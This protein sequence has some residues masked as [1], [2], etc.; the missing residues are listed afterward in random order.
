MI[1]KL[2][3]QLS[4]ASRYSFD[5]CMFLLRSEFAA[6]VEVYAFFWMVVT[7]LL[8]KVS[9]MTLTVATILFLI[10]IATEALNTAIEVIIDRVSPEISPAG[11]KAKDLGSFAVTCMIAVNAIFFVSTVIRS[12]PAQHFGDYLHSLLV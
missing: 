12:G 1:V 3:A 7:L 5:G 9:L 4:N 10:M 6:R 8:L 2:A 11:K